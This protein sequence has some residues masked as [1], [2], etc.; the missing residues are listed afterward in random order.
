MLEIGWCY[1]FVHYL[2]FYTR[3]AACLLV[4]CNLDLYIYIY[5]CVC[6][7][8]CVR[9]CVTHIHTHTLGELTLLLSHDS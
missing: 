4:G 2:Q 7:C 1:T 6:V 3:M 8:V 9:V 5:I